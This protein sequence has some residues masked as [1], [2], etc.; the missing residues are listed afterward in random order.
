MPNVTYGKNDLTDE[1]ISKMVEA[2]N[3]R[4]AQPVKRE[5][6]PVQQERKDGISRNVLVIGTG[7]GGCNIASDIKKK[8]PGI[9]AIAYNTS[10]RALSTLFVDKAVIPNAEDGSGKDRSYSKN[11]FKRSAYKTLIELVQSVL[12]NGSY[13]YIFVTT[14]ADG[15][16]GGGSSPNIA[17]VVAD[18]VNIPVIVIGVYP[19][20]AEDAKAQYNTIAWQTDIEKTGLPY[21]VFDNQARANYPKAVM[22]TTVNDEIVSAMTV[23][24][25]AAYGNTNISMI[26][27][28]DMHMMLVEAG[29]RINVISS[30]NKPKVGESLDA[31]LDTK[32]TAAAQ[33]LPI[34]QKAMGVF[35][36]GPKAF[37]SS[38][39]TSLFDFREKYGDALLYTHIEESP[40]VCISLVIAGSDLP[41]MR[42]QEIKERYEDIMSAAHN[43]TITAASVLEEMEDP[44]R[45]QDN[46]TQEKA[47]ND[48]SGL[49]L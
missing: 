24:T 33:P 26:D 2:A 12:S 28:R 22:H 34:G 16:T 41:E 18:N 35:V 25:G 11:V 3:S 36:R 5:S 45:L 42:L 15:G 48:F 43:Q 39:D 19:A 9:Y 32:M 40:E 23:I 21:M 47:G 27:N 14:T 7:D 1:E 44:F 6:T 31:Y 30:S 17:K 8:L 46:S 20:L 10:K 4:P 37:I 13:E 38:I 49:D 29:K